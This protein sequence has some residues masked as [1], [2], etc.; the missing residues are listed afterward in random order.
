VIGEQL[1][2]LDS[3]TLKQLGVTSKTDRERLKERIKEL[4]KTNE[5]ERKRQDKE[6]K[7]KEKMGRSSSRTSFTNFAR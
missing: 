7:E 6:K 5:K 2:Q 3:S 1:L 4:K